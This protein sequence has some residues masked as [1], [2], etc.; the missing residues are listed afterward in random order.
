MDQIPH[1]P[2][3]PLMVSDHPSLPSARIWSSRFNQNLPL[4]LMFPLSNYLFTDTHPVPWLW[5]STYPCC[6]L[7]NP[8]WIQRS[9]FPYCNRAWIK[10]VFTTLT[11]V[12]L[13]FFFFFFFFNRL[14][15][16]DRPGVIKLSILNEFIDGTSSYEIKLL[17]RE[18]RIK[19]RRGTLWSPL[20]YQN[21][22]SKLKKKK[23]F[24]VCFLGPHPWYIQVP[25]LGV[26][27]ELQLP[28]YTTAKAAVQAVAATY[29][30][31]HDNAGSLILSDARDWTC[32]LMDISWIHFPCATMGTPNT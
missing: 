25:R 13:W 7:V 5:I 30:T 26:E 22:K 17:R 3:F 21:V 11:A 20:R 12:Q 24:F 18:C 16:E 28:A 32:I 19:K 1:L 2:P 9:L 27:S 23:T 10:S 14:R 8:S 29:T 6:I 4:F 15:R 31:A